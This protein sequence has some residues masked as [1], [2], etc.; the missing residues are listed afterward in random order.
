M[1]GEG[2][3]RAAAVF[4]I[5]AWVLWLHA[6]VPALLVAGLVSWVFVHKRLEGDLGKA[7]VRVWRRVWPPGAPVLVPLVFASA[8]VFWIS[9]ASITAKVLPVALCILGFSTLLLGTSRC[10]LQAVAGPGP[11]RPRRD[12][13]RRTLIAHAQRFWRARREPAPAASRGADH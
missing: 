1:N 7:L 3:R 6:W 9:D 8:L 4:L 11:R 13:K 2:G 10:A 5:L 12:S